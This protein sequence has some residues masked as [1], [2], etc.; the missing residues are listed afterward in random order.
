M[1]AKSLILITVATAGLVAVPLLAQ[2]GWMAQPQTRAAAE[3]KVKEHFALLDLNKDGTVTP[4]EAKSARAERREDM[5]A[6]HFDA[7]DTNKDGSISRDEFNAAHQGMGAEGA[8]KRHGKRADAG[9]MG[10]RGGMRHGGD[11]NA[12]LMAADANKDGKV[13]LTEM[14]S[15]ALARFDAADTNKDGTVTPDER[16]A[17]RMKMRADR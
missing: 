11:G 13:S 14:T 4:E 2:Q 10:R 12:M 5:R 1:N 8:R 17:A 3:A 15:S 16:R 9:G 6:K 7:M